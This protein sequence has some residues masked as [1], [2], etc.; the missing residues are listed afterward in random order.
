MKQTCPVLSGGRNK[1]LQNYKKI[2]FTL[3]TSE[4]LHNIDK[5]VNVWQHLPDT[6]RH[7]YW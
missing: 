5:E 4:E 1:K 7:F 2:D 6:H 3:A